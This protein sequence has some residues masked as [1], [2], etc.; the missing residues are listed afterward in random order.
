MIPNLVCIKREGNTYICMHCISTCR[1][2]DDAKNALHL[3]PKTTDR[4]YYIKP[5]VIFIFIFLKE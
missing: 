1:K 2:P 4:I 5:L 3:K